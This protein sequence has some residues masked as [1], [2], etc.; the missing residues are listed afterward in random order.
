MKVLVIYNSSNEQSLVG[1]M[2]AMLKYTDVTL[3]NLNAVTTGDITTWIG[4]LS[5]VY[6]IIL[7]NHTVTTAGTGVLSVAQVLA[8]DAK[9]L[10][11]VLDTG[12]ASSASS[13]AT[14]TESGAGWVVNAYVGMYVKTT[15][16]TGPNQV[17]EILSNS[18]TV[19][20]LASAW[21]VP[22]S[23][24]TTFAI[25]ATRGDFTYTVDATRGSNKRGITAWEHET[26]YPN[27]EP[28]LIV[29][30][31]SGDKTTSTTAIDA[32]NAL[33]EGYCVAAVKYFLR[34]LTD[35]AVKQKWFRL[36]TD[37][38]VLT[39]DDPK[40]YRQDVALFDEIMAY[41]KLL[42][43]SATAFSTTL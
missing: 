2:T 15:G 4:T 24:D 27:T 40:V 34:D 7:I 35:A 20:S 26:L 30:T 17:R 29:W 41:G 23:T 16:G 11:T 10:R 38:N 8:L 22:I 9:C 28:P 1:A 12:T 18:S 31:L 37:N 33:K 5:A 25:C 32:A 3:Y 42:K 43:E 13:G 14:L 19:L 21:T 39:E 36:L 6:D